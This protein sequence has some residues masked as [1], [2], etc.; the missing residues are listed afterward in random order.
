M[1]YFGQAGRGDGYVAVHFAPGTFD[2]PPVPPELQAFVTGDEWQRRLSAISQLARR[3]SRPLLEK[4]WIL[5]GFLLTLAAPIIVYRVL[6]D[7]F[8]SNEFSEIP[9]F[10]QL[11]Q[12]RFIAFGVFIAVL[13]VVW[14]PLIIWKSVGRYRMRTL[15][16][17]WNQIDILAKNKGLFVPTWTV[18]LPSGYSSMTIVNVTIPPRV[19][20][21]VFHPDA[22]LPPYISPP[23]Y[24]TGYGY[25]QKQPVTGGFQEVKI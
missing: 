7:K 25:S 4:I 23:E 5:L 16:R 11:S 9:D 15:I 17:E 20:P 19:N 21:T 6:D 3:Y 1:D 14:T 24:N 12:L 22:Y 10:Q 2:F 8:G 13:I 18:A